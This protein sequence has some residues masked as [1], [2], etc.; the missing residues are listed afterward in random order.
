[1]TNTFEIRKLG[2]VAEFLSGGTPSRKVPEY[3]QGSIPWITGNDVKGFRTRSGR[4]LITEEAIQNS[5]T[6]IVPKG[7]VLFVT[8]TGVGKVSI[9]D[10]DICISQD[11]TGVIPRDGLDS[12]YLARYLRS[13]SESLKSQ[14]RGTTIL[15]ITREAVEQI[16]VPLPPLPIQK[17]IAAILEKADAA[18]EKR[19]QANQLTEQVLQ[20][21]FLEMFGD[22]VTNPKGWVTYKLGELG[23]LERGR[24]KHRPRNAQHLLGGP[25]PLIQT[26][27]IANSSGHITSYTQTYSEAGLHQSRMWPKGTLCITIAANIGKTAILTFDACFPDSIVG[28]TPNGRVCTEYIQRWFSFV[29]ARLEENAPMVAQKNINLEILRKQ[30]V[31]VPPM[32]HQHQFAALVEKVESLRAKQRESEKELEGL[33]QSLMQRAFK[34]ELVA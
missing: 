18:R 31:P 33:F 6:H 12:E 19:L 34:G 25:Y 23:E 13:I 7:A 26:G 21:A 32:E 10:A 29:Q 17:Q 14:Q 2:E 3:F 24:S 9:A 4:E 5:A 1:M 11:L 27:E 22:P 30:T 15:G 28:F 8:R 20:S 16:E